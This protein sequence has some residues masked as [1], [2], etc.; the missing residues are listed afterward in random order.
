MLIACD[1]QASA[2]FPGNSTLPVRAKARARARM[3]TVHRKFRSCVINMAQNFSSWSTA[4]PVLKYSQ[5][6]FKETLAK[7]G[8]SS[9][10]EYKIEYKIIR[11][12][13]RSG[14]LDSRIERGENFCEGPFLKFQSN[15]DGES[16][17]R[18]GIERQNEYV[19]FTNASLFC[20]GE[21][22][23]VNAAFDETRV[24]AARTGA[25]AKRARQ[26]RARARHRAR[27]LSPRFERSIRGPG[28]R[29]LTRCRDAPTS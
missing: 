14:D 26:L 5:R 3:E 11:L 25:T 1:T 8:T 24:L 17:T 13:S 28:A 20:S 19:S 4:H 29:S 2:T 7:Q 12:V 27:S 22:E 6:S 9:S 18:G 21:L 15:C 10:I 23:S 16:P